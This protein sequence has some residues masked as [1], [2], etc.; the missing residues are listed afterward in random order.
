MKYLI[1][2][3][4]ITTLF[5]S[6][7][8]CSSPSYNSNLKGVWEMQANLESSKTYY[9]A[10]GTFKRVAEVR[11]LGLSL[12]KLANSGTWTIE[13]QRLIET[14]TETQEPLLMPSGTISSWEIM[15][16]GDAFMVLKKDGKEY[17][18]K[19]LGEDAIS[20]IEREYETCMENSSAKVIARELSEAQER[21]K[22]AQ[23]LRTTP[24]STAR[25]FFTALGKK[26][27]DN[28]KL[29]A[30]KTTGSTLDNVVQNNKDKSKTFEIT[31]VNCTILA[32]GDVAICDLCCDA[33]G[34]SKSGIDLIKVEDGWLVEMEK[35][36]EFNKEGENVISGGLGDV[37]GD[38]MDE[39]E[40]LNPQDSI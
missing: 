26:D 4:F 8:S 33:N 23:F 31:E 7:Y 20:S 18:F 38:A 25:A 30:T 6:V 28:A 10:D 16:I 34:N 36:E 39:M 37:I 11:L 19:H 15:S 17:T 9:Q 35:K 12:V 13:N 24:E 22:Q 21:E 32:M 3:T 2:I 1:P 29:F 14:V 27:Y 40:T 5:F